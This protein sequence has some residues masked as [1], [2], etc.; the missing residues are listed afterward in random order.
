MRRKLTADQVEGIATS[1]ESSRALGQRYGVSNRTISEVRTGRRHASVR[2]PIQDN[3]YLVGR[4]AQANEGPA[5]RILPH[6]RDE[7]SLQSRSWPFGQ[8]VQLGRF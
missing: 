3:T 1:T 7:P 8:S 5:R 6:H 2:R 4:C